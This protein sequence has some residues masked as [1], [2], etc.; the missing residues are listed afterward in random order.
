[1]GSPVVVRA[2]DGRVPPPAPTA[3]KLGGFNMALPA[4]P[5]WRMRVGIGLPRRAC[6]G[7]ARLP[8]T[9]MEALRV[10]RLGSSLAFMAF[11]LALDWPGLV[12]GCQAEMSVVLQV[13]MSP[14][15]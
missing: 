14:W 9:R 8:S 4:D 15:L 7:G 3:E 1:M 12:V 13:E 11:C 2:P 6:S 5:P 10:S